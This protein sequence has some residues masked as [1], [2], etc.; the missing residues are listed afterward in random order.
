MTGTVKW[1]N[2]KKGFGFI[3]TDKTDVTDI[4]VHYTAIQ[5]DGFKTLEQGQTVEFDLIESTK[6]NQAQNVKAM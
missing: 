6:G 3:T 5:N 1:F 4:F 2:S